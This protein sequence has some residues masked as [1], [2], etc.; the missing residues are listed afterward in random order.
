MSL[1]KIALRAYGEPSAGARRSTSRSRKGFKPRHVLIFDTE[2]TIDAAQ[3]LLFGSYRYVRIRWQGNTPTLS[4]VEEGL[5]YADEL[6]DENAERFTVLQDYR[7][8]HPAALDPTYSHGLPV[9]LRFYSR[10]EFLTEMFYPAVY[11]S[12]ALVA[13]FNLPFDLSRLAVDWSAARKA[14]AGGFSLAVFEYEKDGVWRENRFKPRIVVK[15]IDSKRALKGFA[16][17]FSPDEI[18]TIPEGETEPAEGYIFR[19]N[20]L[21]LRT[22]GFVLTDKGHTLESACEAFGVEHGKTKPNKHGEITPEYIDYNRRDVLATTELLEKTLAEYYRHPVDLQPTQAYSPASLGKAYLRALGIAPVLNRQSDF[23]KDVLGYAMQAYFGGRA[24]CRLRRLPVP[25][26]Y[27]DFTSMY[28]SVNALM[29][30]WRLLT[31]KRIEVLD[32]TR[33]VQELL[34]RVTIDDCF[35][36][37]LWPQLRVLVKVRP[38]GQPL[39]TRARYDRRRVPASAKARNKERQGQGWQIGI[40]YLTSEKPLWLALP[41]LIAAKILGGKVPEVLEAW[42][43]VPVG[44]QSSLSAVELRGSIAVDPTKTDFFCTVIEERQRVRAKAKADGRENDPLEGFLKVLANSTSYGVFAEFVRHE[45]TGKRTESVR[46]WDTEGES[47]AAKTHAPELPGE[48]CFP[49]LAAFITSAARLMLALLEARVTERGGSY[50]FCDTDSMAI[51]ADEEPHLIE[52]PGGPH[53]TDEGKPAVLALGWDEVDEIREQFNRLNPYDRSAVPALVKIERE[54][55]DDKGRR[56]PLFCYAISAKRYVLFY[57]DKR[58]ELSMPKASEHG[59]GHLLNPYDP[60]EGNRIEDGAAADGKSKP[61]WIKEAWHDILAKEVTLR[62][63]KSPSWWHE[64]ALVRI[65]ISSPAVLEPFGGMNTVKPTY[66]ERVKPFN[67]MLSARIEDFGYPLEVTDPHHFHLVTRYTRK[68]REALK[69]TWFNR[70]DGKPYR[71]TIGSSSDLAGQ[72]RIL[73]YGEMLEDY[74]Y[75]P[76]YKSTAPDGQTCGRE[77]SGL[78]GRR[79]I[80]A[81][82]FIYVGKE[83]NRLEE[84]QQGLLHD[85]EEA[86]SEF[87]DPRHS[88]FCEFVLPV[89]ATMPLSV[90]ATATGLHPSTLK[91]IRAGTAQPRT[92]NEDALWVV[93]IEHARAELTR[94][95]FQLPETHLAALRVYIEAMSAQPRQCPVCGEPMVSRRQRYCSNRCRQRAVRARS[96]AN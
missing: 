92:N 95:G 69:V 91:R 57:K 34:A 25:V 26:A 12:R 53:L 51:V 3:A 66:R 76:E 65:T 64:P 47:F 38:S 1:E 61:N 14:F 13:G 23:R 17:T 21:D 83:S 73:T 40:N 9:A 50:V 46:V 36:P 62:A 55:F 54:N 29:D 75:R 20:F 85:E 77:T 7:A 78:L 84:A 19:G 49:P 52:C 35:A 2:T 58:G 89:L 44:K 70:Y 11:E 41:D 68:P 16:G 82:K 24:D 10:R 45:L 56:V 67:F 86:L 59:L 81:L 15:S 33:E 88:D 37:E 87:D 74:R 60:D 28:P 5:I 93:A 42:N 80:E 39:P 94:R 31:A 48:Y 8:S 72:A 96:R 79:S 63:A 6:P 22:L 32:A 4:T 71:V 90:L 30:N 43:L 27:T 18:D